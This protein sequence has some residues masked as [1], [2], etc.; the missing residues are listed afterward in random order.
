MVELRTVPVL[1]AVFGA[2]TMLEQPPRPVT[3][4]AKKHAFAKT[5]GIRLK[6]KGFSAVSS[7][8]VSFK[9]CQDAARMGTSREVA[10]MAT[11]REAVR[12]GTRLEVARMGTR[13]EVARMGTRRE[14]AHMAVSRELIRSRHQRAVAGRIQPLEPHNLAHKMRRESQPF[15]QTRK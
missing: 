6:R 1:T 15:R 12:M 5:D 10:R 7:E 11:C 9:R 2:F 14:A 13:L 3:M 8:R 4:R